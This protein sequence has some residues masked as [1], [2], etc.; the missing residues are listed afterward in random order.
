MAKQLKITAVK[1]S[2]YS[3]SVSK[4]H[5]GANERAVVLTND[6]VQMGWHLSMDMLVGLVDPTAKMQEFYC[7]AHCTRTNKD[8][9]KTFRNPKNRQVALLFLWDDH[10]GQAEL[11]FEPEHFSLFRKMVLQH[12]K[13]K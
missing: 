10:K 3:I 12:L 6:N 2:G 1:N 4:T 11:L 13:G 9:I 7:S 8:V 5:R